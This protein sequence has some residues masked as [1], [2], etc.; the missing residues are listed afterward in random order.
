MFPLLC[1]PNPLPQPQPT[2]AKIMFFD[3]T[4][5]QSHLAQSK[6]ELV[7]RRPCDLHLMWTSH[8]CPVVEQPSEERMG[9]TDG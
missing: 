1:L 2:D 5:C 4:R 9:D 7:H 6:G 3:S 8:Q